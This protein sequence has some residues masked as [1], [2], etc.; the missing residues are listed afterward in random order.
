MTRPLTLRLS[1][2]PR[3]LALTGLFLAALGLGACAENRPLDGLTYPSD[4]RE[5][6]PILLS[7]APVRL[8]VF[9][10]SATGLDARQAAD[11][12]AYGAAFRADTMGAIQV[13][14]PTVAGRP[15]AI[16][17]TTARGV[18]ANL[19]AAGVGARSV[20]WVE[21]DATSLGPQSPLLLSH[22]ALTAAVPHAC[23]DWPYDLAA[24]AGIESFRNEPYWNLGC[25]TQSSLALQVADPVDLVRPRVE[26]RADTVKRVNDINAL[27]AGQDPSTQYA[28]PAVSPSGTGSN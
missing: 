19:A 26:G 20:R 24:G 6:H 11:E 15:T 1:P 7:E 8:D 9:P 25:A 12:R 23:G 10:R 18:R 14:V 17:T 2:W 13:A 5:R 28:V 16:V 3:P 21:Y 22:A 27:R 4:T